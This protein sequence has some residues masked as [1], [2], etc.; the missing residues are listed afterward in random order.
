M[1]ISLG[2]KPQ[3]SLVCRTRVLWLLATRGH[4]ACR[5]GKVS[6]FSWSSTAPT[7]ATSYWA[8]PGSTSALQQRGSGC[9][10]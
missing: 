2:D 10:S 8:E 6:R 4:V 3:S 9:A 7:M 5:A 1:R